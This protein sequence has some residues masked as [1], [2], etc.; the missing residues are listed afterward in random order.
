V[1]Y[2]NFL[3]EFRPSL[4]W[5][6]ERRA[7]VWTQDTQHPSCCRLGTALYAVDIGTEWQER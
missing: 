3:V 4:S 7:S 1:S 5:I 6:S 2:S